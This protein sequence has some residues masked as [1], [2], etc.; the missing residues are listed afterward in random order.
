[1]VLTSRGPCAGRAGAGAGGGTGAAGA[2]AGRAALAGRAGAG[3]G[4]AAM[5]VAALH[6]MYCQTPSSRNKSTIMSSNTV[7]K[8]LIW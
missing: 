6:S 2:G 1:M 3:A 8:T 4:R 7:C 5:V